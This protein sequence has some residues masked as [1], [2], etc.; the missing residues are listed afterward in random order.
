MLIIHPQT[1][2]IYYANQAASDFYGYP[3]D[4]LIGMNIDNINMLTP[5]EVAA[6]R[7]RAANE[8]RNFFVFKHRL[9]NGDIR[10]VHVYSYPVQ[11]SGE[12]YLYSF[13]IDQTVLATT[14]ARNRLL[15]IGV[16]SLITL[17]IITTST[18]MIILWRKNLKVKESEQRFKILHNASFGGMFIHDQEIILDC[19]QGFA[20]MT[21]HTIDELIGMSIFD[22]IDK[23]YHDIVLSNIK[24]GYEKA[25]EIK[26]VRKNGEVFPMITE[27][28]NMIYKGKKVR[29]GEFKDLTEIK[30]SQEKLK[31][32]EEFI[33]LVLNSTASGIYTVDLNDTCTYVNE[34]VLNLLGYTDKNELIG[35]TMHE[36]IHH[37]YEDGKPYPK[38]DC[39][40]AKKRSEGEVFNTDDIIWKKDGT[41]L[42]VSYSSVPQIMDG[43]VV[44]YV[45]T[46]HD[47]SERVKYERALKES[48]IRFQ[49][50][51]EKAPLGYQSLDVNGCLLEVNQT[52]LDLFGYDKDE[53]IGK[54]F[55]DFLHPKYKDAFKKRFEFFKKRGKIHSEFEMVTKDGTP[56]F[57][58]FEGLIGV[59]DNNQF[60]QTFCT[61]NDITE[62]KK[63]ELEIKHALERY[64]LLGEISNT[65]VW[66]FN[67]EQNYLWCSPE[68]FSMLGRNQKDYPMKPENIKETWFDLM[69]PD[70]LEMASTLFAQYLAEKPN[71]TYENYFRLKTINGD[72]RWIWSRGTFIRDEKGSSTDV[73]IGTHIDITERKE[74]E[75]NILYT[76][77]H[78]FLTGL[79][80]RRYFDEKI[81]ELDKPQNYPMVI[82]M[83][84]LDGLKMMNDAYG[85][86]TGDD[87]IKTVANLLKDSFGDTSFISRLG[88]DEFLTIT[89]QTTLDDF[90]QKR[91][92]LLRKT[93]NMKVKDIQVSLS[94]G[95][96]VKTDSSQKIDQ[97]ITEAENNMYS[98]KV[99][100]GQSS[101]NQVIVALFDALK[102]KHNE[103]RVH[104]E[105]VSHYCDM[106]GEKLKLSDNEKAELSFAG[107]MHD[108]GK[109][110]ILDHILKKPGKLTDDE[111]VIMKSHTTNGYQILRSADQYS[112]LAEYALTHHERMDGKGYPQGLKGEEIPLF[113]RI[114][115]ICDSYEAMTADRPYRQALSKD[116]AIA[117]LKRCSG[118]QFDPILVEVFINEVLNKH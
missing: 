99:L 7:L 100:H 83:I 35:K 117:E 74:N 24:I 73:V 108:I 1:G 27:A 21:G 87:A 98:N 68:Y 59:D 37:S 33:K 2:V 60:Q 113:S 5:D 75:D 61:L 14:E 44:G 70:D 101:R 46:F 94:I 4:D 52:W 45:I 115:S 26:G 71:S 79:P 25:Y 81:K 116:F 32:S 15:I 41:F 76:S 92:E 109:I 53:V 30:I 13:I 88:G 105:R 64:R 66:E 11:I 49:T 62:R 69:H 84:D 31:Q 43:K 114:I 67:I 118:T 9:A 82:A 110:T 39:V 48:Y 16:L 78:D 102:E 17:G 63:T 29:T 97:V 28:R 106:M 34:N 6:E 56:L 89:P 55:G 85:H 19:N 22:F 65:G 72:Y 20:D 93:S 95:A 10:T 77:K 8:E 47:I 3:L 112:R 42:H 54:W 40:L 38:E 111:W 36:L 50:L 12:T 23:E 103:E 51:F 18:L 90:K 96:A 58:A 80:N 86:D 104:S 107:R 57:I 91:N